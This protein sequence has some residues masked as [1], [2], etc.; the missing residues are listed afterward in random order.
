MANP[1]TSEKSVY[2]DREENI[3]KG[4]LSAKRVALYSYD[5]LTDTLIPGVQANTV[6]ERYDYSSSTEIYVG[7]AAVGTA[8]GS[9]GWKI[10]KYDL[11]SASAAS[12][13]IATDVSW[14]NKASGSYA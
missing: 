11:A 4:N 10:T 8:E 14:T 13:K 1:N 7:E 12:G 9:L 6:T 3:T 5:A 2:L